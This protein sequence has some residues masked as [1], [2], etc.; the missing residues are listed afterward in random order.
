MYRE[1]SKAHNYVS[2]ELDDLSVQEKK[3]KS[4]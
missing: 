3:I 2:C 1:T 4:G